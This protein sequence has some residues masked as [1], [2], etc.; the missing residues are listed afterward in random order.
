[1]PIGNLLDISSQ[2]ILAGRILVGRRTRRERPVPGA[3]PPPRRSKAQS[4]R[5]LK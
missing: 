2:Q 4:G 5:L 3:V 1:M